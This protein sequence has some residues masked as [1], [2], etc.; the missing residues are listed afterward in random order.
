MIKDIIIHR[1][2][3][4][5]SGKGKCLNHPTDALEA[6]RRPGNEVSAKRRG[7]VYQARPQ[8]AQTIS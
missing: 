5:R 2:D 1:R 6:L 4:E 8:D 3:R 7:R